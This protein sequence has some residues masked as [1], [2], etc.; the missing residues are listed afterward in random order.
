[1]QNVVNY[2]ISEIYKTMRTTKLFIA[3][4]LLCGASVLSAQQIN[5]TDYYNVEFETHE[6]NVAENALNSVNNS[7]GGTAGFLGTTD[8]T[9]LI[10]RVNNFL[11]G[12]TGSSV[13]NNVSFGYEALG[14]PSLM[15]NR[16]NTAVGVGT[17][18]NHTTGWDNTAFGFEALRSNTT[19]GGNTAGGR[20][21]LFANT[22]GH[23]NV[24]Y[25][26]SALR[27]NTFG[28]Y[29]VAVGN[30]ALFNNTTGAGNVAVGYFALG[31]ITT[32]S[33]NTAIGF[34][35]DPP[36]SGSFNNTT[37]IGADV[38]ITGSNQVR[39]G[40]SSVT[41]IGGQVGWSNPSDGRTKRNI[42]ANVPGLDFI[43]R[44]QPV[45]YNM[46]LDALDKL[47]GI[48]RTARSSDENSLA[49]SLSQ[50]QLNIMEQAR[51]ARQRQVQTGFVA[52]EV[53]EIARS[54]GY[55]FSG[56]SIDEMGIYSLRYSEFVVPL[57]QA[58]QELNAQVEHLQRQLDDMR[59]PGIGIPIRTNSA[60]STDESPAFDAFAETN[61]T[62]A[63][64]QNV[65]NPFN[66]STQIQYYLPET[67]RNASLI[68]F[69]MQGKQ[70][71]QIPL[72]QR[73]DGME[74]IQGSQLS[75]G[76]YLYALIADG[77]EVGVKRMILT[78]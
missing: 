66:Q 9:P 73:G 51:E 45:T 28:N 56:V 77:R 27:F 49:Q 62:A 42:T 71:M 25:G 29:N 65:P 54:I 68:I 55:D 8:G 5:V 50:E 24:A 35:L 33:S 4:I 21:A 44:L 61:R 67:V 32:G 2:Q 59:N 22:M 15:A 19:G 31:H 76:I 47:K 48:D 70:L 74:I 18:R 10:F 60:P 52:Q 1:M 11:A 38:Y 40:N 57:V 16:R 7:F 26:A 53:A 46:N 58:V 34:M 75:A 41:S 13:N 23:D 6:L 63:L 69:D 3:A 14:N 64:Y 20:W 17:L 37:A 72:M 12:T 39:I 43:N 30:L 36:A 78:Q